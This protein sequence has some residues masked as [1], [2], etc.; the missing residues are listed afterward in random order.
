MD[1]SQRCH[2]SYCVTILI[3]RAMNVCI[4]KALI[5]C[6][7]IFPETGPNRLTV[8]KIYGGMLILENWKQTRFSGLLALPPSM[9][10]ISG[11]S[12]C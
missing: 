3:P 2:A 5:K 1:R 6:P 7:L 4:N 11:M 12:V 10:G 9:K 8:G